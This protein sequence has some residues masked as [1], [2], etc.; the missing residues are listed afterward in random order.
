MIIPELVSPAGSIKK[1][2]YAFAYGADAVYAGEPRYS[3]RV[4]NNDFNQKK[5]INGIKEAHK[6]GKLFYVVTNIIPHNKKLETLIEDFIPIIEANPDALII[7]DPGIIMLIKEKFPKVNIHLSVQANSIN[8]A[9]VKFW[10]NIGIKRI[11]LSRELSINEIKEI[12][13]N[14]PNIELEI[15]IH[16]SLCIAY[17]GRCLLSSYIN[18]TDANQ[19]SCTNIC[20]QK[21][22]IKIKNINFIKNK[23]IFLKLKDQYMPIFEDEHG[24]Y[25]L[26]SK[27][28]RAISYIKKLIKIGV[29]AFKI[30][31]R[32]KS[33]YYCSRTAQIYKQA[34]N[35]SIKNKPFN[36]YLLQELDELSNRGYTEGFLNRHSKKEKLQNY[37]YGYSNSVSSQFV[38]EFTG[39]QKNNL[40][41]VHVKNKFY[42][43]D[44]LKIISPCGNSNFILKELYNDRNQLIQLA[45]GNN[46]IIYL[47][48]PKNIKKENLKYSLLVK[49]LI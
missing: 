47:K 21:Y 6:I 4:R 3:L 30:E 26:N 8:W 11:I 16:G 24:S 41:E 38:G 14:V 32:T 2:R 22:D 12:K 7:S 45:P 33:L 27:D 48:I 37:D 1:M 36:K 40:S 20:R 19:G 42:I 5:I 10:K 34:I 49:I 23:N 28:L 44:K 9:T 29:K 17:S 46:H 39:I 13:K 31:G 18:K 43:G 15:F 35:D 25:I